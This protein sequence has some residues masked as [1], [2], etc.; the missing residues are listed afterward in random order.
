MATVTSRS[1]IVIGILLLLLLPAPPVHAQ[2]AITS[3]GPLTSIRTTSDLG[4]AVDHVDDTAGEFYGD[5]ACGTF[6]ALGGT[7]YGPASIPAGSAL[8]S[9]TAFTAVGQTGGG[10]GTVADPYRITTTV[11]L[12]DSGVEAR[13]VDSYVAGQSSFRTDVTLVNTGATAVSGYV[14]RAADCYLANSDSGFGVTGS[15]GRVGCTNMTRAEEFVPITGGSTF[16]EAG[17]SEVWAAVATQQA[18]PNTCR[19]D[20]DIDNGMAL[21]W[22]VTAVGGGSQVT[23]SS[24]TSFGTSAT[25]TSQVEVVDASVNPSRDEQGRN[26][27]R[28]NRNS[29]ADLTIT[30]EPQAAPGCTV[31][32]VT[33][34]HGGRQHPMAD[35]DGDGRWTATIPRGDLGEADITARVLDD[36]GGSALGSVGRVVFYDPSGIVTDDTTGQP[37][38]GATVVLH[39]V[40]GWRPQT[41]GDTGAD[42]CETLDTRGPDGWTQPAP[43]AQGVVATVASGTFTPDVNPQVTDADGRYGWD[44]VAGCWYVTVEADGYAPVTSPVVGV[45]PEVTDLDVALTPTGG[46]TPAAGELRLWGPERIATAIAISQDLWGDQAADMVLLARHD[47]Y[48]DSLA[49]GPLGVAGGGP[50]LLTPSDLL[51]ASTVEEIMRVLPPG[52]PIVL[53]GGVA[54]LSEG[55]A[56]DLAELGY[57]IHRADGATRYETAVIVA[58]AITASP[59]TILVADGNTFADALLA[60]SAAP[61]VGGT[62]V[63]TAGTVLPDVVA[64]YLDANVGARWVTVGAAAA[65]ALP[66]A[67]ASIVG[68]DAYATST[69]VADAFWPAP[70]GVAVASGENF[71]DALAGSAHSGRLGYPLLLSPQAGM[72]SP[73]LGWLAQHAPFADAVLYGGEA[74]LSD[75]VAQQVL[76]VRG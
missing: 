58:N 26:V 25:S 32:Q 59:S 55:V 30:V 72:T 64:D 6:V 44:V 40:P 36:C 29:S 23:V 74:A 61:A 8:G 46:S 5:T 62:V 71:P 53:L 45:P 70:V 3:S 69:L 68:P 11:R 67:D 34:L 15:D 17:Y 49:G 13:Q 38:D 28:I 57:T 24:A 43:T 37:V 60:S 76:A 14:Y 16:L 27:F 63:L 1:A 7:L 31:V 12:G 65:A 52:G 2:G 73:V 48:P 50:L 22:N 42:T 21:A 41:P 35:P 39:H 10:S 66:N 4:C 54:A 56:M 51:M 33:L 19:C 18:L 20:E 47:T 75:T 9:Y